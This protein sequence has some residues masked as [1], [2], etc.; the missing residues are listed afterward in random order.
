[1]ALLEHATFTGNERN[2]NN[3][4]PEIDKTESAPFLL[5]TA[6]RRPF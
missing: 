4:V 1:V 6:P 3:T 5:F 2:N